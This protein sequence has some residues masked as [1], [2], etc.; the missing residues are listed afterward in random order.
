MQLYLRPNNHLPGPIVTAFFVMNL[1]AVSGIVLFTLIYFIGKKNETLGLL[2]S[3]Q[4][5][6]ESLLLNILPREIAA[7]LKNDNRTI[8]DHF[9]GARILFADLVGF[10]PLTAQMAPVEMVNLLSEIF[11]YFDSLVEKYDLEKIRTIGDNYMVAAGVPRP[12]PDHA[13][14]LARMALDMIEYLRLFPLRDG[15][16]IEFRIGINS[17]PVVGGVIGRKKFVYDLWGDAV[18]IASRMESQGVAGRIQVTQATYELIREQLICEPR[19]AVVL[20]GRGEM[21][22]WFL[23]GSKEG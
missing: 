11:S 6:T 10:T 7:I 20:K 21:N 3:E 4:E 16:R 18:N 1:A 17:G 5:K 2:R 22:T 12:R 19:G 13:Q 14:A 23:T 8:A 15:R 9:G